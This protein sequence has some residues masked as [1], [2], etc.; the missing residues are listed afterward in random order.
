MDELRFVVKNKRGKV[1][2]A[3]LR[4]WQAEVWAINNPSEECKVEDTG[5]LYEVCLETEKLD[6]FRY[7]EIKVS[8]RE[9]AL[10]VARD[11]WGDDVIFVAE[12]GQRGGE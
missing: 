6:D 9:E 1:V 2:A 7:E 5:L 11:K 8:S 3:F 12:I 10:R 4:R